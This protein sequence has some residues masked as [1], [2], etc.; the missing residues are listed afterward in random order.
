MIITARG[1][2]EAWAECGEEVIFGEIDPGEKDEVRGE[3]PCFAD[4][5]PDLY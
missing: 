2:V 1:R 4:R 5:R 3:I